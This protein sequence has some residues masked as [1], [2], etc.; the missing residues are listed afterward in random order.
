VTQQVRFRT[1]D[2]FADEPPMALDLVLCRNV[3]IYFTREQQER[4]TAVFHRALARGG[5]LVLGRTEKMATLAGKGFEPVSGR[6]R[7]YR[8]V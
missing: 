8:K 2:L 6:E 1:L 4:V 3:F 5:Y 7:V